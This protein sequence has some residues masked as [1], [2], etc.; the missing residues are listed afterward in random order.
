MAKMEDC[1]STAL[2]RANQ[3]WTRPENQSKHEETR[4]A[5]Q[6]AQ[7]NLFVEKHKQIIRKL[8]FFKDLYSDFDGKTRRRKTTDLRQVCDRFELNK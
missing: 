5:N 8:L 4:L 7:D 3:G 2:V 1:V 6:H